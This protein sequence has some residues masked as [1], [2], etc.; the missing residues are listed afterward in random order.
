[1]YVC[2]VMS[3]WIDI[4]HTI[5]YIIH[6]F[7]CVAANVY[8][9]CKSWYNIYIYNYDDGL[10]PWW[11]AFIDIKLAKKN[12]KNL[13]K[14]LLVDTSKTAVSRSWSTIILYK[15]VYM[16]YTLFS[17]HVYIDTIHS[18]TPHFCNKPKLVK[19]HYNITEF[20]SAGIHTTT[21]ICS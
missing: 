13:R 8:K 14:K 9:Q 7:A 21:I 3:A 12:C 6:Y 1:M 15:F 10:G 19:V 4:L 2:G 20:K 11:R 16:S 18:H 17:L 5:F